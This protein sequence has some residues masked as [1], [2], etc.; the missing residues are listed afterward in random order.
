M[1]LSPSDSADPLDLTSD[2]VSAFVANNSLRSAELPA[3]I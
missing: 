2:I 1:P 3:L